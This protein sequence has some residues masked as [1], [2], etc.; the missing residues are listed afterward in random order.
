MSS[1]WENLEFVNLSFGSLPKIL[2]QYTISSFVWF[3]QKITLKNF[4]FGFVFRIVNYSVQLFRNSESFYTIRWPSLSSVTYTISWSSSS[5]W[6][7]KDSFR[8]SSVKKSSKV[9]FNIFEIKRLCKSMKE[10]EENKIYSNN[11]V[12]EIWEFLQ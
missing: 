7:E 1:T 8:V 11:L 10:S 6:S 3:L 2:R 5:S 4:F 9:N 12:K